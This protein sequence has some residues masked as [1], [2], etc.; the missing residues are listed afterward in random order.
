VHKNGGIPDATC[1]PY[2]AKVRPSVSQSVSERSPSD[3]IKADMTRHVCNRSHHNQMP[4]GLRICV[5]LQNN[6]CSPLNTCRNC[7]PS[8]IRGNSKVRPPSPHTSRPQRSY[9]HHRNLLLPSGQQSTLL[10][11]PT[12]FLLLPLPL[13]LISSAVL[14]CGGLPHD[15]RE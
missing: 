3:G 12:P 5:P 10:N 14:P 2:E 4:L 15:P 9:S 1:Q 8:F 13:A 7:S 11:H 6:E